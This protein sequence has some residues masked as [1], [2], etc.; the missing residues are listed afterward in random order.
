MVNH[1]IGSNE[2]KSNPL[3]AQ[4][5]Y[6]L[7]KQHAGQLIFIAN[8]SSI[9][10]FTK[11]IFYIALGRVNGLNTVRV[12]NSFPANKHAYNAV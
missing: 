3:C 10:A 4:L 5:K 2:L 1:H 7:L 11:R 9:A 8:F 12:H 6:S